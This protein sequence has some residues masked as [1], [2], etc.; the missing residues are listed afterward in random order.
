MRKISFI[1]ISVLCVVLIACC[2]NGDEPAVIIEEPTPVEK[3]IVPEVEPVLIEEV[4]EEEA[5]VEEVLPQS[6]DA[7]N[8]QESP[9][10]QLED[11]LIVQ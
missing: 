3:T 9:D 11:T 5:P 1:V 7:G 4:I 2:S 10:R 8:T 6:D